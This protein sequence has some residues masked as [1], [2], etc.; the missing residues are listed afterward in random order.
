MFQ[1]HPLLHKRTGTTSS[2]TYAI[3][4]PRVFENLYAIFRENHIKEVSA[5]GHDYDM[6]YCWNGAHRVTE[7]LEQILPHQRINYV[8]GFNV[9]S[10]KTLLST[11]GHPW[12]PASFLIPKDYA[13]AR[14]YADRFPGKVFLQKD[15]SH[16]SV[17]IIKPTS[18]R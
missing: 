9:I 16:G 1:H 6:L 17:G 2:Y 10:N 12:V 18:F 11:Y 4:G 8:P 5:F 15:N 7:H 13:K 14:E 3:I